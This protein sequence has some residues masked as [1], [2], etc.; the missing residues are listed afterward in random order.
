M[1]L[2]ELSPAQVKAAIAGGAA[3]LA[4]AAAAAI[5]PV[6][7]SVRLEPY[8]DPIGVWTVCGGE[9]H[10]PM[11]R[12]TEKECAE[13]D[14]RRMRSRL[15]EVRK[16]NPGIAADPYQWAAHTSLANN[17]G[18]ANYTRSSTL[19]LYKQRRK[20]EACEAMSAWRLA[21]GKVW[22][23]LVLRR[24]GDATRLGEIELCKTGLA[25]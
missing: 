1:K 11:R 20:R 19:R 5:S 8:R 3:S 24:S 17:I 25:Q 10:V 22:R 18:I 15:E 13:I 16:V 23:G 7:E 9:T 4:L 6:W 14:G 21:G 2:G 12:Y